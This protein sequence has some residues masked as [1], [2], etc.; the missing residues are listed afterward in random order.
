VEENANAK[1]KSHLI[2][3][4]KSQQRKPE[5]K[6]NTRNVEKMKRSSKSEKVPRK[7][8]ERAYTGGGDDLIHG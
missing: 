6:E 7:G 3:T 4:L 2:A 5:R 8:Y 1:D